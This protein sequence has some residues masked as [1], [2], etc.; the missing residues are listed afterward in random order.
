MFPGHLGDPAQHALFFIL[1]SLP[2]DPTEMDACAMV[3]LRNGRGVALLGSRRVMNY[4]RGGVPSN[5]FATS[6][7]RCRGCQI[8]PALRVT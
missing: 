7:R 8:C 6:V 4:F 1:A 5:P 2:A 3:S